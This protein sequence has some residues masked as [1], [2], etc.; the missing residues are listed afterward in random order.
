M[1]KLITQQKNS[2]NKQNNN[3]DNWPYMKSKLKCENMKNRN[4][5]ACDTS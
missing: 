2:I 3:T 1:G 4:Y 5:F